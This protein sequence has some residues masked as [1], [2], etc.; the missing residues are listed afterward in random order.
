[1]MPLQKTAAALL[2]EIRRQAMPVIFDPAPVSQSVEDMAPMT[3]MAARKLAKLCDTLSTLL[4]C[5]AMVASQAI[6]LHG[7]LEWPDA[8]LSLHGAIR[9]AVPKLI[10]DRPVGPDV[11]TIETVL[12]QQA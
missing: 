4:A 2:A 3:P 5:E 10:H 9:E 8:V 12:L 7:R 1:M 11:T 6:D